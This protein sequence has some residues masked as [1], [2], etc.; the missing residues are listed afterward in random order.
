MPHTGVGRVTYMNGSLLTSKHLHGSHNGVC[1]LNLSHVTYMNDSC[2]KNKRVMSFFFLTHLSFFG[3]CSLNVSH[4]TYMN[5]SCHKNER[6]MSFIQMSLFWR[7]NIRMVATKVFAVSI[8][9]MSHLNSSHVT[10]QF[11]SCHIYEWVMSHIWMSHVT[12]MNE[13]CHED[14]SCHVNKWV[15]L[16]VKIFAWRPRWCLQSQHIK[17]DLSIHCLQSQSCIECRVCVWRE[18]RERERHREKERK[19]L[20]LFPSVSLSLS[21][22]SPNTYTAFNTVSVFQKWL[23]HTRN[24]SHAYMW[25]DPLI[26]VTWLVPYMWYY[27]WNSWSSFHHINP[28]KEWLMFIMSYQTSAPKPNTKSTWLVPYMRYYSWTPW[29]SFHNINSLKERL[30]LM[31]SY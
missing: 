20:S 31:M 27:S 8:Q 12:Y 24:S 16:D 23:I 7:Q 29:S 25:H 11:K 6:V 2:H 19:T 26:F 13:S 5:D 4:V 3:V 10:S 21:S 1:S 18:R 28:W 22:L 17:R 9:V 14:K 15:S 30:M